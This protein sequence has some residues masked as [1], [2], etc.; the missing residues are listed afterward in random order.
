MNQK[1]IILSR[2]EVNLLQIAIPLKSRIEN[3]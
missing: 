2:R 1:G 3:N